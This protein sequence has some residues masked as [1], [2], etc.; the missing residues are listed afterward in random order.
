MCKAIGELIGSYIG[1]F[2]EYD[3][4]NNWVPWRKFMRIKVAI[5][6]NVPLKKDWA[7][8][9]DGGDWVKVMFKY[10]RLG[11]FCFLCGIIGH[12][13][14]FC[15]RK[16]EDDYVEGVKGWG[17]FLK[18]ESGRSGGGDTDNR[19]LRDGRAVASEAA[20]NVNNGQ[21]VTAETFPNR[22]NSKEGTI[23]V[24]NNNQAGALMVN[25]NNDGQQLMAR[26]SGT[27]MMRTAS[28]VIMRAPS[29]SSK[30]LLG[31]SSNTEARKPDNIPKQ[32]LAIGADSNTQSV[33]AGIGN[34]VPK[35]R[36][37]L[38]DE[39]P[40]QTAD[41]MKIDGTEATATC[42]SPRDNNFLFV[43]NNVMAGSVDQACQEP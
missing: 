15:E 25:C 17:N 34:V 27:A 19:W 38:D 40:K 3:E 7:I 37:R 14:K 41:T 23:T 30:F 42:N 32:V 9:K 12:T 16:F 20:I 6:V 11:T 35:K 36:V 18:S 10:E 13:D 39:T 2:V 22:S 5:D 4:E 29:V 1:N 33:E 24:V 26:R 8:R 21:R 31:S 28:G 43:E